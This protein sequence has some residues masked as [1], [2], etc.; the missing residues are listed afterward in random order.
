MAQSSDLFFRELQKNNRKL[1]DQ[2][3]MDYY[4]DLSRFAFTYLKNK[5]LSEEIVQEIFISLWE[6]RDNLNINTSVR[7]FLYTSVRNR[8]LNYLRNENTRKSHENEFALEQATK[9]SDILDFC[10]QEQLQYN[11]DDAVNSL[12]GQ[13]QQIF[14]LSR[15]ENLT[16]N[17]I[18][19]ELNISPK[20]VENQMGIALKKLRNKLAPYLSSIL[21][22]L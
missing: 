15:Y 13:C 4:V 6:R 2:L 20:T 12:P 7:A 11:I 14:K 8:A 3:F 5:G 21:A 9:T 17:E 10:L 18:A 22:F 19:Q 16:Y 1:F